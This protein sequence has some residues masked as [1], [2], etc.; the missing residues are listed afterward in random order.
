MPTDELGARVRGYV[1]PLLSDAPAWQAL[2]DAPVAI[3]VYRVDGTMLLVNG[4]ALNLFGYPL[5][6]VL[7]Q[8]WV[9]LAQPEAAQREATLRNLESIATS[10]GTT[11]HRRGVRFADG[12]FRM[13]EITSTTVRLPDGET[14][15]MS[16]VVELVG[17][18]I[19][20]SGPKGE[21]G[22]R[23]LV[24]DA[25]DLLSRF[26][27][28]GRVSYVNRAVVRYTGY[29]PDDLYRDPTLW[30]RCIHPDALALWDEAVRQAG[31]GESRSFDLTLQHRDGRQVILQQSLYPIRDS[32]QSVRALEGTAR[33]ITAVREIEALKARNE[34]RASLDRL[35]SQLLANVSH[36]LRTPLVSIKGYNELLL[37][38]ALGPLTPRQKRGLEIAGANTERLIELI[39]SLLDFARREEERLEMHPQHIDVRTAV[40]D[41]IRAFEERIASRNLSLRVEL[42]SSTI[43]VLGDRA[44]LAQVFRALIGNAEKFSETQGAE[45]ATAADT[46]GEILVTALTGLDYVE[47]SVSDRGIGIPQEAH[48]KI[49]DRFYQVDASSTRRY[50]GAGL[51]LALAKEL[52]TLHHGVIRVESA[53][54]RGSTFTVRLPLARRDSDKFENVA[55]RPVILLGADEDAYQRLRGTLEAEGLGHADVFWAHS[56]AEVV[57]RARRHRPDV[58]V[59]SLDDPDGI[60]AQLKRDSETSTL[61]VVVVSADNRR[62]VGRA[63][64]VAAA[65]DAERLIQGLQRLLGRTAQVAGPPKVVVVEDEVEILDFTKFVLEREGYEVVCLTT[66]KEALEAVGPDCGLVILDIALEDADGVE[67][68]KVLKTAPATRDVPILVMTAMSGDEVRQ[69]SLAAGADGYLVK[70]FGVDEFLRQVRLHLKSPAEN[71]IDTPTERA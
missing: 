2:L 66:G 34:E 28:D 24:E 31:Q 50:G 36:E 23:E 51:G 49:F 58:V 11:R 5:D 42:G 30:R 55:P 10:K 54:G 43:P 52:V 32:K 47:I 27:V 14:A 22:Y 33:D 9:A 38:G 19:N 16:T 35:K 64:L 13:C 57:R 26:E 6:I 56:G 41:A 70:P 45:G 39:E 8:G 71:R 69:V 61:P 17:H 29:A 1:A 44:R 53:E 12:S 37:R 59:L 65:G 63:D 4:A 21:R 20:E 25:P 48:A 62:A 15:V 46:P 18:Q 68:A 67:V 60:V 3:G 7:K 40:E